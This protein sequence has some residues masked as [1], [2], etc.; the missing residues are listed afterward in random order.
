MRLKPYLDGV[1]YPTIFYGHRLTNYLPKESEKGLVLDKLVNDFSVYS[2]VELR[3]MAEDYLK[4]DV[5]KFEAVIYENVSSNI[6]QG[7][8]DALVNLAFNIGG[9]AFERASNL[10]R[11]LN[12]ITYGNTKTYLDAANHLLKFMN[13]G[14]KPNQGLLNRRHRERALFLSGLDV[15]I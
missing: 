8:F 3:F 4:S 10:R 9:G 11:K 13:A 1:G 14:G 7:M 15:D 2:D 5:L 6:T 12:G